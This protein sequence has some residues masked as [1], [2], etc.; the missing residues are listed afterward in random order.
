MIGV[1]V[2]GGESGFGG[3][4]RGEDR[5]RVFGEL[6]DMVRSVEVLSG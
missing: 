1:A 3:V 5:V 2:A 4:R 6:V